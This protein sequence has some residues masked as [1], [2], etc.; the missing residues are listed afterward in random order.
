MAAIQPY[1]D[2]KLFLRTTFAKVMERR[3]VRKGYTTLEGFWVDPPGYVEKIVW[4]N[5]VEEHGELF[6]KGD[7][8]GKIKEDMVRKWGIV[9]QDGD[10]DTSMESMLDWAVKTLLTV[11][12]RL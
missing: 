9:V 3:E 4:G 7:V 8:E 5:Y 1:F 10:V 11:L 12:E 2:L 6:E